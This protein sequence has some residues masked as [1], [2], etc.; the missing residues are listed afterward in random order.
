MRRPFF[1]FVCGVGLISALTYLADS[2]GY[3]FFWEAPL[4]ALL[5]YGGVRPAILAGGCCLA[6]AGESVAGLHMGVLTSAFFGAAVASLVMRR[7][8]NVKTLAESRS[9]SVAQWISMAALAAGMHVAFSVFWVSAD[10]LAYGT[11]VVFPMFIRRV[12]DPSALAGTLL[13]AVVCCLLYMLAD[14]TSHGHL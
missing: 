13:I 1:A 5:V 8:L 2:G 14:R 11:A 4:L 7:F 3:F 12:L 9:Y 10:R 6:V